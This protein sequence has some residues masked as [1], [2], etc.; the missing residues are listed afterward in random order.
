MGQKTVLR[1]SI[2]EGVRSPGE[3]PENMFLVTQ[4]G[5]PRRKIDPVTQ[6]IFSLLYCNIKTHISLNCASNCGYETY[7]LAIFKSVFTLLQ[8]LF[9]SVL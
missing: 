5:N 1:S 7:L 2:R 3:P 8:S 9:T 6:S 4:G